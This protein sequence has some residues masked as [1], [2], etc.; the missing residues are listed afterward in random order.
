MPGSRWSINGQ[1]GT[2]TPILNLQA[3]TMHTCMHADGLTAAQQDSKAAVPLLRANPACGWNYDL[4][5]F[6]GKEPTKPTE[7]ADLLGS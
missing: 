4:A 2:P 5:C 3:A 6:M 7:V 1:R